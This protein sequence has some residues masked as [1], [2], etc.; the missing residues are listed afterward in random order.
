MSYIKEIFDRIKKIV[1]ESQGGMASPNI[2]S[3]TRKLIK[4]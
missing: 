3:E 4:G 1:P 2:L